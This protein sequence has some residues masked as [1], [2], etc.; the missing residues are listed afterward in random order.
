MKENHSST[1]REEYV[2]QKLSVKS[3][4]GLFS[5]DVK[6]TQDKGRNEEDRGKE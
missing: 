4:R 2:E 3:F 1:K 5:K 6:I